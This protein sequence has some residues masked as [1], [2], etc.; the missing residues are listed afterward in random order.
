VHYVERSSAWHPRGLLPVTSVVQVE[1]HEGSD[2]RRYA[3]P[4][5]VGFGGGGDPFQGSRDSD[6]VLGGP[7]LNAR[8]HGGTRSGVVPGGAG[9]VYVG[10]GGDRQDDRQ[11]RLGDGE[12]G[13]DV[14]A[15]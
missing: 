6:L 4:N 7:F 9:H 8:G 13:L 10:G 11:C 14:E 15:A 2:L 3:R 5:S 1:D 12:R